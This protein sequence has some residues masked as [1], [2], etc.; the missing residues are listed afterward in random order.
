MPPPAWVPQEASLQQLCHLLAEVQ[1]PGS[2]QMQVGCL[3]AAA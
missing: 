3:H 2:N 1:R